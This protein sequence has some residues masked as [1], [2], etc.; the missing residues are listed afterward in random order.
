M[1]DYVLTDLK[2]DNA[3]RASTAGALLPII[4]NVEPAGSIALTIGDT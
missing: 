1:A 3:F 2:R 4:G